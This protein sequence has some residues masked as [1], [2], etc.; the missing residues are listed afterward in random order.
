MSA[1][2]TLDFVQK[3][4]KISSST[5]PSITPISVQGNVIELETE[6]PLE[7]LFTKKVDDLNIIISNQKNEINSLLAKCNQYNIILSKE[8][9]TMNEKQAKNIKQQFQ[10]VCKINQNN[11]LITSIVIS[12]LVVLFMSTFTVGFI[13]RWLDNNNVDLFSSTDKTNEL[14]LLTIQFLFVFVIVNVI[15]YFV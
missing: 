13:D 14:L 1:Y 8:K 6:N 12:I 4:D 9:K 3:N 10:Q 7:E 5:L 11:K 2:I 15:L